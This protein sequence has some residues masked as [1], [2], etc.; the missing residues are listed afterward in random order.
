MDNKELINQICDNM[1]EHHVHGR[2]IWK[3][4]NQIKISISNE[5]GEFSFYVTKNFKLTG[6]EITPSY[7]TVK[8]EDITINIFLSEYPKLKE[9]AEQLIQ[10]NFKDLEEDNLKATQKISEFSKSISL[11]NY[12]NEQINKIL[13]TNEQG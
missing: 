2:L 6:W 7:F 11:E 13:N 3:R 12:R 10:M 9:M 8:I 5:N 4:D 1:Y